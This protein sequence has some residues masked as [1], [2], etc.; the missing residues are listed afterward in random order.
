M[1]LNQ[2]CNGCQAAF[3]KEKP[4]LWKEVKAPT[5]HRDVWHLRDFTI[6]DLHES[7]ETGCHLCRVFL[8]SLLPPDMIVG[9]RHGYYDWYDI[10]KD[11]QIQCTLRKERD[12]EAFPI[13]LKVLP[14]RRRRRHL[15]SMLKGRE[16]C[17][18]PVHPTLLEEGGGRI[19]WVTDFRF[20]SWLDPS[21][22]DRPFIIAQP[23]SFAQV[24]RWL[25][26]CR[27]SHHECSNWESTLTKTHDYQHKIRLIDVGTEA[28]PILRLVDGESL[29]TRRGSIEYITLSYRWTTETEV[30]SLKSYNIASYQVMIPTDTLPPIY[31]DAV[32]VARALGVRYIWM[33]S[34]CIIQ[35]SPEDWNEQSSLMDQIYTRGILNLS[36]IFAERASGLQT[37]RDPLVVSPCIISRRLPENP[38]NG[39][40]LYEHWVCFEGYAVSSF[41]DLAPL[42]KRAWC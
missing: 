37:P 25:T 36:A 39:E 16:I 22:P 13:K 3:P 32:A 8:Y 2:L 28:F 41:V 20:E 18:K 6:R 15:G 1:R 11:I 38:E 26:E 17:F 21:F 29:I 35:D 10:N 7:A 9:N 23:S 31:M 34:L 4:W 42:F 33:D 40:E 27:E 24:R 30:I 14:G 12:E 5:S 19:T